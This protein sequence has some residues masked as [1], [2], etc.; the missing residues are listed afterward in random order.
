MSQELRNSLQAAGRYILSQM[1]DVAKNEYGFDIIYGDTDSLFLNNISDKSLK[2]FQERFNKKYDIELEIKNRYDK[3]ILSAGKKHYIG[4]E[5]GEPDPV[6]YEGKKSDRCLFQQQVFDQAIDDILKREVD[7]IP[8]VRKAFEDL[9]LNQVTP[10][11][12][13]LEQRVNQPLDEYS[14]KSRIYKIAIEYDVKPGEVAWFYNADTN[15]IG[16]SYTRNPLEIDT[17]HYK[18]LLFNVVAEILDI[19]GHDLCKLAQE[20]GVK[21][22]K[23]KRY[24]KKSPKAKKK[25]NKKCSD[26]NDIG[27]STNTNMGGE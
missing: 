25:G 3:L 17:V 22:D 12:L 10:E 5:N 6:G 9:D 4:Y 7:P 16:K 20:F 26:D 13:K 2:E 11:L 24:K 27:S 19:A 15:K 23:N 18:G 8:K 21:L 14:E 1:Q